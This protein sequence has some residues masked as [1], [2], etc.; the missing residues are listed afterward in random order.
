MC[1]FIKKMFHYYWRRHQIPKFIRFSIWIKSH[2]SRSRSSTDAELSFKPKLLA[3]SW[4]FG[5]GSS[6]RVVVVVVAA[7]T[8]DLVSLAPKTDSNLCSLRIH[9]Q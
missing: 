8:V 3:L 7:A 1:T 5:R 6:K 2:S 4:G 9:T